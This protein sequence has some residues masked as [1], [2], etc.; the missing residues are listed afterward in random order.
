MV[1]HV[2]ELRYGGAWQ[3]I[4]DDVRESSPITIT[5]G[6]SDWAEVPD[7]AEMT[8]TLNNGA[9]TVAPGI[10]GRYTPANPGSDLY[11]LIGRNT[12]I[13]AR[14]VE[15]ENHQVAMPGLD[16]SYLS[17]PSATVGAVTGDLDVRFDC[18]PYSWRPVAGEGGML[19]PA[20]WHFVGVNERAW[21]W[22]L[23]PDGRLE[24]RLSPDGTTAAMLVFTSTD[25]VDEAATDLALR[26]TV[27]VD[28]GA[29]GVTV[30]F[31]LAPDLASSWTMLGDPVTLAGP[32]TIFAADADLTV[33]AAHGG[34]SFG[35]GE[36]FAGDV[37]A[38][39][40]RS[41][42]GGT[43]E[44]GLY[45]DGYEPEDRTAVDT[46]ARDWTLHGGAT[47]TD[48]SIRFCGEAASWPQDWDLSGNDGWVDLTAA[49]FSRRLSQG[50][51][52]LQSSLVRDLATNPTVVAYY[53]MEEP[54]GATRFASG[55]VNDPSTLRINDDVKPGVF[56]GFAASK[57]LPEFQAGTVTGTFPA[58]TVDT[59][60]RFIILAAVP[61]AP[62]ADERRLFTIITTGGTLERFEVNCD[63]DFGGAVRITVR[64]GEGVAVD[65]ALAGFA[66]AGELVMLSVWLEQR[67]P[68]AF[69]Q[70]ARFNIDGTASVQENTLTG[71]TTGRMS[72]TSIGSGNGL[73][74]AALGHAAVITGDVH[75]IWGIAK[76]VLDAWS[77]ESAAHRLQRLADD[78][79]LGA[80]H[81]I[82]AGA[83]TEAMGAQRTLTLPDLIAEIPIVDLGF[84]TDRPDAI[85]YRYRTRRSLYNQTPKL[86]LDYATGVITP[87]FLP[88]PDDQSTRNLITVTRPLGSS[89]TVQADTG[90]MSVLPPPEGV[91]VY[92]HSEDVN[93]ATDA[94]LDSQ[95]GWRL[96][97]GT[98]PG[99]RYANLR[100][101]LH[102]P[103]VAPLADDILALA[104]GDLVRV[105]NLPA[106][107]PPGPVDL[108][109]EGITE[110]RT[111]ITTVIEFNCSPGEAWSVWEVEHDVLGR[112]DTSGSALAL[113]AGETE[114]ELLVATDPGF[115][116]WVDLDPVID[117]P[118]SLYVG[119][120]VVTVHAISGVD[121][122]QTMT[123]T[124]G[125]GG[126]Q[127]AWPAGT[128]VRLAPVAPGA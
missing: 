15:R 41:G 25:P 127:R 47:F 11:G 113:A 44:C 111:I 29:G 6:R 99:A 49:G 36:A 105:I 71:Q 14:L 23:L 58:F 89:V 91:G 98:I 46:E 94:Q 37:R 62:L 9:S 77:G 119:S 10:V 28:N 27:D 33:G 13:R 107:V 4:T 128:R 22:S 42:I 118:F 79:G 90:P 57:P 21:A 40:I 64:D 124:R 5:R 104:E 92:T 76:N 100:L 50:T 65:T 35:P 95:A 24:V 54:T 61:A 20:R 117:D 75:A 97:L 32:I 63:N 2:V 16:G 109:I 84:L 123:V 66:I 31:Y 19:L 82:G 122:P 116:P 45:L 73:E 38:L 81:V 96:H 55:L 3:A 1:D 69:W 85:G 12:P 52:P 114:T 110:E 108:L 72:S 102:G 59:A 67:G 68:D 78:E 34:A 70:L 30:T 74:G 103:N 115:A 93:V 120:E 56:E 18:T 26:F 39:E 51:Q 60:Q 87:P 86:I 83:D 88:V 101:E 7:P 17:T 121:S 126:Y 53:P 48:P 106:W 43:L 80:V 8:L 125:A 112:L